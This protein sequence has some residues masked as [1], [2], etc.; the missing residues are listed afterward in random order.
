MDRRLPTPIFSNPPAGYDQR[1]MIDLVRSMNDLVTVL[2]APGLGRNTTTTFTGLVDGQAGLEPGTV[3][4]ENGVARIA[5]TGPDDL[6]GT[7]VY[8]QIS[9]T[10]SGTVTI[11]TAGQYVSTGLAG[12]LD[13]GTAEGIA[14]G[15]TDTFAVKNVSGKTRLL[16]IF[17]S[18]DANTVTGGNKVLGI[19]LA[20]NGTP[21]DQTECRAN[22]PSAG[23]EAKLVT[24]WIVRMDPDDEIALFI[25]NITDTTNI[26][27]KRGRI[28]VA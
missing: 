20:L 11:G 19:K 9:R 18:I 27:F 2:R 1:Y 14:L 15:T 5:G 24:R 13:A 17:G 6:V 28:V 12:T 3:W 26:T 8:G 10:T 22:Q 4:N 25:A 16:P 21:I 23:L 7:H